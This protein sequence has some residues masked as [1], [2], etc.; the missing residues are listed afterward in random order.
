MRPVAPPDGWFKRKSGH[1]TKHFSTHYQFWVYYVRET[2]APLSHASLA[3]YC[4]LRHCA[5]TG[6]TPQHG[7]S[8]SYLAAVLRCQRETVLLGL[9]ALH[10]AGFL[11]A[12]TDMRF[13]F[14]ELTDQQL[15]CFAD[16]AEAS[17]KK[18]GVF[19]F[20]KEVS[21]DAY[22]GW[23]QA[24]R[25]KAVDETTT[26][27]DLVKLLFRPNAGVSREDAE[28]RARQVIEEN[29]EEWEM[30]PRQVLLDVHNRF[31]IA[32]ASRLKAHPELWEEILDIRQGQA[33][34]LTALRKSGR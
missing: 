31:G 12:D 7:F 19:S 1:S 30:C 33:R 14:F 4:F 13:K 8:H 18:G 6:F 16:K 20:A 23:D 11:A 2:S 25:H 9:D 24:S 3:L 28:Q 26:F 22:S 27:D 5:I 15:G 29:A 32:P 17:P 34:Q 10:Q 21:G